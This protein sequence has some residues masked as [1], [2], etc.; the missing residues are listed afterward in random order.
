MAT[1]FPTSKDIYL[2]INGKKLAVAQSYK[3]KSTRESRYIEAFGSAQP[4]GTVGGRVKYQ[5]ELTRV[6]LADSTLGEPIR[7]HDLSGFNV[8]IV[9]PD[10]KIIYSGCEWSAIAEDTSLGDALLETV[11]IVASGRLEVR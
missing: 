4:V 1:T 10:C 5:L 8:V 3:A 7:F 11:S 9:K 6:C 2:E